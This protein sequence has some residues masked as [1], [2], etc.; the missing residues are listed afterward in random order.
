[1]IRSFDELMK[2]TDDELKA[3][4]DKHAIHTYVG[5]A[6]YA[7]ELNRRAADRITQATIQLARRTYWLTIANSVLATVAAGAAV[8][9]LLL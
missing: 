3:E 7:D 4:H 8:T 5:T 2:A 6:Y 1:M 9:A